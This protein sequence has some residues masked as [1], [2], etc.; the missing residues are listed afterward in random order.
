MPFPTNP[1]AFVAIGDEAVGV[2]TYKGGGVLPVP[3]AAQV[4]PAG[5][6]AVAAPD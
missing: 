1:I 2:A 4:A 5:E 6:A 3:E